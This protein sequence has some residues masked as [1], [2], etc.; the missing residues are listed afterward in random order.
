MITKLF[1]WLCRRLKWCCSPGKWFC[2]NRL[3]LWTCL[4]WSSTDQLDSWAGWTA[5]SPLRK[6]SVRLFCMADSNPSI[7]CPT[8][9]ALVTPKILAA[10]LFVQRQSFYFRP[11]KARQYFIIVIYRFSEELHS[12]NMMLSWH[13]STNFSCYN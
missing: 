7:C 3:R 11:G 10:L 5:L 2:C 6:R 12:D 13:Y 1:D 8:W 9:L 4:S